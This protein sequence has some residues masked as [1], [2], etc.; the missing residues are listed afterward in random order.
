MGNAQLGA[1]A[2]GGTDC[3]V[4][5][6]RTRGRAGA[7]APKPFFLAMLF[8][9]VLSAMKNARFAAWV[10]LPPLPAPLRA[11]APS[12]SAKQA[13]TWR[14]SCA[15]QLERGMGSDH[16][17]GMGRGHGTRRR[18]DRT[19]GSG[20]AIRVGEGR[21]LMLLA[22]AASPSTRRQPVDEPQAKR[23][24]GAPKAIGVAAPLIG[25]S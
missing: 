24:A 12:A 11:P 18:P 17:V 4:L 20:R 14:A 21:G 25:G 23:L 5:T 13:G 2:R 9:A 15:R 7:Q 8:P 19:V 3:S 6:G 16:G 22:G 10:K 1:H